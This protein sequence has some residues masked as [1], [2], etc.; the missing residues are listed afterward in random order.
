[1]LCG[2]RL[3]L[4]AEKGLHLG[5]QHLGAIAGIIMLHQVGKLDAK[6]GIVQCLIQCLVLGVADVLRTGFASGVA[7]RKLSKHRVVVP[8]GKKLGLENRHLVGDTQDFGEH[9]PSGM[10]QQEPHFLVTQVQ[11]QN[12]L[13]GFGGCSYPQQFERVKHGDAVQRTGCG[14]R[15]DHAVGSLIHFKDSLH[16]NN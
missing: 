12:L 13:S 14:N 4:V 8:V 1:M 5:Q 9:P 10:Y 11:S 7:A 3:L 15:F 2:F 16:K 6:A